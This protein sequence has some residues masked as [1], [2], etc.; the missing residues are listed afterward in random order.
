[1]EI[2]RV[3][4]VTKAGT[5]TKLLQMRAAARIS[6]QVTHLIIGYTNHPILETRIEVVNIPEEMW[7]EWTPRG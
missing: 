7:K 1:M 5:R 2:F 3:T 4:Q 6:R